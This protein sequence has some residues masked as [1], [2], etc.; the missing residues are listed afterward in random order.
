VSNTDESD[1]RS[2]VT[3]EPD[4]RAVGLS[5]PSE[6]PKFEIGIILT[7]ILAISGL[8]GASEPLHVVF[9]ASGLNT[10]YIPNSLGFLDLFFILLIVVIGYWS[11]CTF[12]L[13]KSFSYPSDL[14][15]KVCLT[16]TMFFSLMNPAILGACTLVPAFVMTRLIP[17]GGVH[18]LMNALGLHGAFEILGSIAL[19]LFQLSVIIVIPVLAACWNYYF[20]R[21]VSKDLAM[22][23][24]NS[25]ESKLLPIIVFCC[26]LFT[27]LFFMVANIGLPGMLDFQTETILP[28]TE[29][30]LV[31]CVSLFSG[32][33]SAA[34]GQAISFYALKRSL[35]NSKYLMRP[36]NHSRST[37]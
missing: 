10:P 8:I 28:Y 6:V 32:V 19:V 3:K 11:V 13:A 12:K 15:R 5:E 23:S 4:S 21:R 33:S 22:S 9:L 20:I 26:Q 18:G 7:A 37:S 35:S 24:N 29:G 14:S 2:N 16:F 36:E 17:H 1:R 27:L 34:M 31:F 30:V 25:R